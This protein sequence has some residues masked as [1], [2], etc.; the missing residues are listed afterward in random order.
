MATNKLF[1]PRM[2]RQHYHIVW[3]QPLFGLHQR[4]LL[5]LND[6]AAHGIHGVVHHVGNPD[7]AVEIVPGQ[8]ARARS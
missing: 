7:A 6:V 8:T 2:I 4:L 1:I 3:R 5:Q